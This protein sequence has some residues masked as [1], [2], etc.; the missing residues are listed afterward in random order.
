VAALSFLAACLTACATLPPPEG[1]TESFALTDTSATAIGRAVAPLAARHPGTTGIYALPLGSDGFAARMLIAAAAERSLDLQYYIWHD[2]QAGLLLLQQVWRAAERGVRVRMLL[3][4]AN[5][6]GLDDTIAALAAHP[7]IEVRLYNPL[8][9][10]TARALDFL[11]DFARVNRRM[12]NKSFT[13]DNQV[14]VV[15]GRNIGNEYFGAGDDVAFRDL[16]VIAIGKAAGDVS[17]EFDLYWNSASAYPAERFVGEDGPAAAARLE[18]AFAALREDPQAIDFARVVRA[19][20]LLQRLL[21]GQLAFE[22]TRVQVVRD[23]PAKTL[24]T[25]DRTDILL[26]TSVLEKMGRPDSSFDLISPYF[27]PGEEG[28]AML[29]RLARQGLRI[30]VLTNSLASTDVMAVHAG[31]AKR[32]CDL[33]QAGVQLYELKLS[34]GAAATEDK[35]T[36]GSSGQARLHAKTFATDGKRIFVG[37]FNFDQ[38]SARLNTEMGL[39]IDSPDL[40]QRLSRTFDE[41]I[42][43]LAYAIR[44]GTDGRCV[45]WVEHTPQGDVRYTTD[46]GTRAS[47]RALVEL[48]SL[49][50]IDWLL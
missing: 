43:K 48:L 26:L 15:G 34:S 23:D 5:T 2:D 36:F 25:K 3:D 37:S 8:V 39:V 27:V 20:P 1:R 45:E 21:A 35:K 9:H 19:T 44:P 7:N 40:A 11:T 4:D 10:R 47:Q 14:T 38:R 41:E 49:L 12:H 31:Y 17:T 30:R 28:T 32:R 13:A 24:D 29:A 22:W 46:P 33:L 6:K 16:D 18:D 50:P 42:P